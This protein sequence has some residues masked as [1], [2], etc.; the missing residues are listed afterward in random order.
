MSKQLL[1]A[2]CQSFR[3]SAKTKAS[4][5]ARKPR[6]RRRRSL[7]YESLETREMF[8]IESL[9]DL[10]V[11]A[12][13]GEKPQ[14][15][16]W[17]YAGK[18]WTAMPNSTGTWVHRLDG[19][20]WTPTVQLSSSK[21]VH[22]DVKVV[23][24]LAHVLLF[25]GSTAQLATLQYDSGPDQRFEPWSVRPELVSVPLTSS[26]E[27]ATL[28]VDSTGRMWVAYDVSSTIEV[29]YSDGLYST[30]S[31]PITVASGIN[32]DDIS[33]IVAFPNGKIGVFWSNQSTNLFGFR[34]HQDGAAPSVWSADERPASQ[35]ALSVGSGLADDHLNVAVTSDGTLYTAVK[36]SY[37]KSSY[38][39]IALL[40]RRPNGIWD[41][42]YEVDNNGTRPVVVVNEAAN[43]LIVAY[44]SSEGGGD[45]LYRES[46]LDVVNF[47]PPQVLINGSVNNVTSTK[48]TVVDD[49]VFLAAS[50]GAANGVRYTFDTAAP[51][52]APL[53][54]AGQDA[55][56]YVGEPL[57]LDGTASDDGPL[58][59]LITT[60]SVVSGP[61]SVNF[62][63]SAAIDT[64]VT[65]G[66]AGNYILRL[67]ANDGQK[68]S[69][70]DVAV[71]VAAEIIVD[72][73]IPPPVNNPALT[74]IA[75]Q[76]G[77]FPS[78]TYAGT[79]D[80]KINSSSKTKNYGAATSLLVDGK[81]DEA[82]LFRWDISAIPTGSVI[83]SAAIELNALTTTK[84][85]FEIYAL[86][87]AWDEIS[88]T[89]KQFSAGKAWGAAGANGS[90]DHDTTVLG[91]LAPTSK[92]I[93]HIAL[94]DAGVAAVQAWVNDATKNYGIIVKDY[95]VPDG[96]SI[97]SSEATTASMR[98]KLV[99]DYRPMTALAA[100]V[101]TSV[102]TRPTVRAGADRTI[103]LG[104][105][106]ALNGTVH[107][108]GNP[109]GE[110][111]LITWRKMS[112]PGTVTFASATSP[113][114]TVEFS[115]PGDYVL[116]LRAS[117]GELSA[118]DELLVTVV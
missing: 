23:G 20:S 16:V 56:T 64:N 65:F 53:V 70:D 4:N 78:V 11:A 69:F 94:N 118:I 33:T 83:V 113:V 2:L 96:V 108:D 79:T 13:T 110:M 80:T 45:I 97:S 86:Q 93:Q 36:T 67:T 5:K 55:M 43:R 77:V 7:V 57:A 90:G 26:T 42:L 105:T 12:N 109:T 30:W 74:Q 73:Q 92:G 116:R 58:G 14:S 48:Q 98:P 24:D 35:S 106:L 49:V 88:A 17:E 62:G 60:W 52:L 21:S 111:L 107:D 71:S 85:N 87:R 103:A 91:E 22:T 102:N 117:D 40:V 115:A 112:G 75:F 44:T 68:S 9:Q 101:P 63:N 82:S 114:T 89:W 95:A 37:D 81:P 1:S 72:P 59:S 25:Q 61:G 54:S 39:K 3:A 66:A 27:T 50:G 18:W 31:A 47:T 34:T 19:T 104:Q 76:D 51:N 32:S 10:S 46:P 99:I 29:R 8:A 15:K 6:G 84:G 100:A 38:P 41:N 28:E